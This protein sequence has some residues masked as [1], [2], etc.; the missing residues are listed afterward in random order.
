[1]S[2]RL[3]A[4]SLEEHHLLRAVQYP[5]FVNDGIHQDNIMESIN[6]IDEA[7]N[8]YHQ[9]K[10]H[11]KIINQHIISD[12]RIS[13]RKRGRSSTG[14]IGIASVPRLSFKSTWM[15]RGIVGMMLLAF[16]TRMMFF[17]RTGSRHV[18]V[19]SHF[20]LRVLKDIVRCSPQNSLGNCP[21]WG[22]RRS[23]LGTMHVA[24]T[25][26]NHSAWLTGKFHLFI[27]RQEHR[28]MGSQIGVFRWHLRLPE[29]VPLWFLTG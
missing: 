27:K 9:T 25:I 10:I 17:F 26:Y 8:Q 2:S 29:G 18:T 13:Q 20:C 22:H 3:R 7:V 1:M 28:H 6:V 16:A 15:P 11:N 4:K 21:T 12:D 19:S 5:N 24:A 23:L 14:S